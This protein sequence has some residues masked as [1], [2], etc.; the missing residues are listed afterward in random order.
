M[1]KLLLVSLLV[2]CA[3][4]TDT[5]GPNLDTREDYTVEGELISPCNNEVIS[6]TKHVVRTETVTDKSTIVKY[7]I[8]LTGT[9][10]VTGFAYSGTIRN[11]FATNKNGGWHRL[12]VTVD[13]P[14]P[15]LSWVL[16]VHEWHG[17]TTLNTTSCH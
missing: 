6:V 12:E 5:T 7:F 9:G 14:A 16:D 8:D 3:T 4:G 13:T 1:R 15:G 10:D 11:R 17:V 2:G